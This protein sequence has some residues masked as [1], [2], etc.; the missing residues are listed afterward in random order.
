MVI[1]DFGDCGLV[2]EIC[3][4]GFAPKSSI[5]N[6]QSAISKSALANPQSTID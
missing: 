6:R 3:D 5:L 1:A 4:W 2:V